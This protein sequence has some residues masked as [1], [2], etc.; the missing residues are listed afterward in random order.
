MTA[1][2]TNGRLLLEQLRDA[3]P[4][5]SVEFSAR[6]LGIGKT[7]AYELISR[8]EYPAK[9]LPLGP[10]FRVVTSDLRQV[11]GLDSAVPAA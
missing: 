3:G 4:T 2:T 9:V 1:R 8:G 5:V 7:K 10:R 11:L 6:C